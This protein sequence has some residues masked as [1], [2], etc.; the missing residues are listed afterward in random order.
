MKIQKS[1]KY[2]F[3]LS[4]FLI[5]SLFAQGKDDKI[6]LT[7]IFSYDSKITSSAELYKENNI[8][9]QTEDDRKSPFLA[10]LL[11]FLVPGAGEFYSGEYLKTGIFLALEAAVIAVAIIYDNKGDKQTES[12]QAFANEHWSVERYAEWSLDFAQNTG[13]ITSDEADYFLNNL[14]TENGVDFNVLNELERAIGSGYSHTLPPFGEQQYYELIGKYPQYSSG[15]DD[16]NSDDFHDVSPNFLF[17]AGERGEANDLYNIASKAVIGIYI[18][19]FLSIIDAVW[20]AISFNRDLALK[21]R[22]N[23]INFAGKSE[24]QPTINFSYSF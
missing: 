18:N 2:F 5:P 20:S 8:V 7:G 17:Y 4:L 19:H 3:L 9:I 11:S 23:T 16:F 10:G 21:V 1:I 24:F 15:W 6:G 13:R 22:V 14:Y 12:F